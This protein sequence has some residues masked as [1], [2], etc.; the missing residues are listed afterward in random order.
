MLTRHGGGHFAIY[1][2]IELLYDT[3]IANKML[4]IN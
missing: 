3:P 2:N 4:Y 1:T